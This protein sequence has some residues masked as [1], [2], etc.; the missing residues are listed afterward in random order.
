MKPT[1]FPLEKDLQSCN[2]N[3]SRDF[4]VIKATG[5]Y[6]TPKGTCGDRVAEC[7]GDVYTKQVGLLFCM[8]LLLLQV[9]AYILLVLL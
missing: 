8:W 7:L 3:S 5:F 9:L 1:C 6:T 4:S 2:I